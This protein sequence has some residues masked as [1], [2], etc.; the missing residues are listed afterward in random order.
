MTASFCEKNKVRPVLQYLLQVVCDY[1][2][3]NLIVGIGMGKKQT[4]R[5]QNLKIMHKVDKETIIK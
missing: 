5:T 3:V 4:C 1:R 2:E